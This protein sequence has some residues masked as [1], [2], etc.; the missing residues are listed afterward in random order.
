MISTTPVERIA[1][2]LG[3]QCFDVRQGRGA[4]SLAVEHYG[5]VMAG[6]IEARGKFQAA[7]KQCLRIRVPAQTRRYLGEH[8]QRGDISRMPS[9]VGS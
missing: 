5:I 2:L 7:F 6:R 8:A 3:E 9:E 4:L 1:R